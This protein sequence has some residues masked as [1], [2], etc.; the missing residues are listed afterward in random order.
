MS[1]RPSA[2]S[3]SITSPTRRARCISRCCPT[4]RTATTEQSAADDEIL[5]Y[6]ARRDRQAQR[7]AIRREGVAALLSPAPPPAL[8]SVA[9][10][11]WMG[12]ER[13]RGKLHE[14]NLLLRGDTDTTFLPPD[15]PLPEDVVYVMTLD[16]DTRMM[17]DAVDRAGRQALP[18]A[19][20]SG[21][22]C[23]DRRGRRRLFDP[24]A[25]RHAVADDRRRGVVPPARL[26]GQPR[27]RPLCLRRLR[28]LPGRVRRGLL[29]RQGPLSHR[30]LGGGAEGPHPGKRGA[31]PRSARRRAGALRRWS[32]TSKWSRTIRPAIRST[33][34]AS[35]AGRAA[36]GSCCASSSIRSPA[37]RRCRAGRWSTI[38]AAR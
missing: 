30:R 22:R 21:H 23:R 11:C 32:P 15:A 29:H 27:H 5:D 37:C 25:A 33:R 35:I 1:R 16:A 19:Q 4:G 38:C 20:P 34:R 10:G 2:S 3:R 36:T 13:K 18:S 14:L 7:S 8:Q 28:P 12:W 17:R 6:R 24:A 31:Q 9:E 26:L